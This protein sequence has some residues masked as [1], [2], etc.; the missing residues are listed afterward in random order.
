MT[1]RPTTRPE[2]EAG[3]TSEQRSIQ[4]VVIG[5]RLIEVLE[6]APGPVSLKELAAGAG[7]PPSRAHAYLASLRAVGLV[8]QDEEGGRYDLGPRALSLGLAALGRLEVRDAALPAMRRFRDATGEA[9][10]L[11]VWAGQ[12][13]VIV[14][15]LDGRRG[16][17]LSIRIGTMLPLERSASGR[18][19]LAFLEEADERVRRQLRE[20]VDQVLADGMA[21]TD[22]LLNAGFAAI[23]VPVLDH[24]GEIAGAV[25]TLGAA[26]HLDTSLEGPT[27]GAL[28]LAGESASSALG[29]RP[30]RTGT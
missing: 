2:T 27:A 11:S 4:S 21:V 23:S 19:F 8:S 17:S 20:T 10:H 13:P 1:R 6:A 14:S 29:Y 25:T 5:F 26:G 15:R 16:G 30:G 18:I 3:A 22:G 7:M 28:R 9:V 12:A 24:L